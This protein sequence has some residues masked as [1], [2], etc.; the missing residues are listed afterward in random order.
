MKSILKAWVVRSLRPLLTNKRLLRKVSSHCL[1]TPVDLYFDQQM[2]T[3]RLMVLGTCLSEHLVR[4]GTLQGHDVQHYLWNSFSHSPLPKNDGEG[5]DA[6]VVHLT[7]RD[8]L[9][10]VSNSP[11]GCDFSHLDLPTEE[12]KTSAETVLRKRLDALCQHFSDGTPIFFLSFL[13]P[14]QTSRGIFQNNRSDG[15]FKLVHELNDVMAEQLNTQN[16][17]YYLECNDILQYYGTKQ[18][19]SY[20]LHFTHASVSGKPGQGFYFYPALVQRITNAL[21]VL[22][23]RNPVKIIITDLDNTLWKGI[24]A[25]EDEV[26]SSQHTDGW[27]P[28]Y[29]EALLECKRRGILLAIS[30]KND[31]QVTIRNFETIW[32]NNI[33]LEDFAS[34]KI[35][36]KAKSENIRK[37]L[38]ETNLQPENALFI[39]DSPL[40]IEEVRR[41]FPSIRTLTVPQEQWRSIL[42]Y[43]PQTQ[44]ALFTAESQA[45]TN[46]VHAKIQRDQLAQ[47]MDRET[48]LHSLEL[49]V[50]VT[51]I[52]DTKHR[53]FGRTLELLNKTNQFNTTGERWTE[54]SLTRFLQEG[55]SVFVASVEDRLANHGLVLVVLLKDQYIRQFV[56]SC[57]VFGLGIETAILHIILQRCQESGYWPITAQVK[58]TGRNAS[59]H[60]L[61][62][63]HGFSLI[64][65]E[66]TGTQNW[67]VQ[68]IPS[69]PTWIRMTNER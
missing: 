39:D 27:V 33:R 22:K 47:E 35:N 12:L 31:E 40:E 45:R 9:S 5:R 7:L 53:Q 30:S 64:N 6:I 66:E 56:L 28:G 52:G 59:C 37:I 51:L 17:A 4:A 8:I 23:A 25:E 1:L 67:Q 54:N 46:L 69:N 24:P 15:I 63:D 20:R 42:L 19:D 58:D 38:E 2:P 62:F 21:E 26:I 68:S 36:W 10:E 49:R 11:R 60:D 29:V 65:A 61:Y 16:G 32:H 55:G 34:V 41:V 57:R 14:P 13:E 48:F 44:N 3:Y 43:A 18:A 50:R